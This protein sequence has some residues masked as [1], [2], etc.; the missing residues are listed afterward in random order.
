MG[1]IFRFGFIWGDKKNWNFAALFCMHNM[2]Y[3]KYKLIHTWHQTTLKTRSKK[4]EWEG[5]SMNE[6]TRKQELLYKLAF[7]MHNPTN[8]MF[9]SH[10]SLHTFS[11]FP[12]WY[13]K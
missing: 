3:Q 2:K 5:V 7:H 4:L 12:M 8:Q 9:N 6:Q 11:S 1:K 10:H 13:L